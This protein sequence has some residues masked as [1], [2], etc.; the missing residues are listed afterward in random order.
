MH[1]LSSTIATCTHYH[2]QCLSDIQG[3]ALPHHF[4]VCDWIC[5]LY[6]LLTLECVQKRQTRDGYDTFQSFPILLYCVSPAVLVQDDA[7]LYLLALAGA[8]Q[9]QPQPYSLHTG[10]IPKDAVSFA[11]LGSG[12][13]PQS[14]CSVVSRQQDC[15]QP[16]ISVNLS[17][18][19]L[20]L[21]LCTL[22]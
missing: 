15:V 18:W 2:H 22:H 11:S 14:L 9:A 16:V 6:H 17:T 1:Q 19:V 8:V 5:I 20:I 21:V 12:H 13:V 4:T 10:P 3:S 7:I